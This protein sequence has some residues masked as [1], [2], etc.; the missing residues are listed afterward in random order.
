M[1]VDSGAAGIAVTKALFG[2]I[3][4]ILIVILFIIIAVHLFR[5]RK[6]KI[7]NKPMAISGIII[8][9]LI[10][11]RLVI[12]IRLVIIARGSNLFTGRI[13]ILSANQ[14]SIVVKNF[15]VSVAIRRM[16]NPFPGHTSIIGVS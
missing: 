5:K 9:S 13:K 3:S 16:M 11:I 14:F 7:M 4:L 1:W 8:S 12:F 6:G 15:N 10:V 2:L